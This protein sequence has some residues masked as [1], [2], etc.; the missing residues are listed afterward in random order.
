ML[1]VWHSYAWLKHY[2]LTELRAVVNGL[3]RSIINLGLNRLRPVQCNTTK[4]EISFRQTENGKNS[5]KRRRQQCSFYRGARSRIDAWT[6]RNP[7]RVYFGEWVRQSRH[8]AQ[9]QVF[10]SLTV[11]ITVPEINRS[12]FPHQ[13][14]STCE[15]IKPTRSISLYCGTQSI[16]LRNRASSSRRSTTKTNST[17]ESYEWSPS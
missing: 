3:N 12:T 6:D 1:A 5:W 10:D 8:W 4:K 2:H 17:F 11:I 13:R 16:S 14:H 9:L 15:L 7:P